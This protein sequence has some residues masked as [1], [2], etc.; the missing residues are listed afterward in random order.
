MCSSKT[1][2]VVIGGLAVVL[3]SLYMAS[4]CI[5]EERNQQ[6]ALFH[7]LRARILDLETQIANC[8]ATWKGMESRLECDAAGL[9]IAQWVLNRTQNR[10]EEVVR[11]LEDYKERERPNINHLYTIT[12]HDVD[13]EIARSEE[14]ID[15]SKTLG[16]QENASFEMEQSRTLKW[17]IIIAVLLIFAIGVTCYRNWG[18]Q[19]HLQLSQIGNASKNSKSQ[20]I[21]L[22]HQ[23]MVT[24][25]MQED[26]RNIFLGLKWNFFGVSHRYGG[27]MM[28][29]KISRYGWH[30]IPNWF[31]GRVPGDYSHLNTRSERNGPIYPRDRII[32]SAVTGNLDREE[33]R[34]LPEQNTSD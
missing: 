19:L 12:T 22:R 2:G 13:R 26:S 17:V 4:N 8:D 18:N 11:T 28:G 33:T 10:L 25:L 6:M 7:Q 5:E 9:D 32:T 1:L 29:R 21:V 20:A 23:N 16:E 31:S 34:S 15:Q 14:G 3:L 27:Q 30:K 24:Q